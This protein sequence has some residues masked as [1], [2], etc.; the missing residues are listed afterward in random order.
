VATAATGADPLPDGVIGASVEFEAAEAA[1]QKWV[2]S[3][4]F[5]PK[6]FKAEAGR[7]QVTLTYE[8]YWAFDT[9][10]MTSYEGE[11]GERYME[12]VMETV[13]DQNGTHTV[14]REEVRIRWH[15]AGGTVRR[16]FQNVGA[17]AG[18]IVLKDAVWDFSS[19]DRYSDDYLVGADALAATV[20]VATGW[21]DAIETMREVIEQDVRAHIGGDVQRVSSAHTAYRGAQF[22]YLLAPSWSGSYHWSGKDYTIGINAETGQVSG[23]RPWSRLKIGLTVGAAVAVLTIALLL[24]VLLS[25]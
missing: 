14:P 5:A 2:A 17:T 4:R 16:A 11:R 13:T 6:P 12:T 19:A 1:V 15:P 25:H 22:R 7:T 9:D 18:G 23:Q 10:T 8:P 21:N 3:R 20:P 24:V